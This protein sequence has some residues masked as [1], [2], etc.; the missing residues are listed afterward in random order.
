MM[1]LKITRNCSL[2]DDYSR[3]QF[4]SWVAPSFDSLLAI[5]RETA[6]NSYVAQY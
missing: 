4:Y 1:I 6:Y 2:E 5:T 3:E